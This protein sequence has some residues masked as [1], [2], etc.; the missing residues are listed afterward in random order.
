MRHNRERCI[1]PPPPPPRGAYW[2]QPLKSSH[3]AIGG[4]PHSHPMVRFHG[5]LVPTPEE[6]TT[7]SLASDTTRSPPPP[8]HPHPH[9]QP[10]SSV[11]GREFSRTLPYR[12]QQHHLS[13]RDT[14]ASSTSSS[15]LGLYVDRLLSNS[16]LNSSGGG[17]R[18]Q[19]QQQLHTMPEFIG[20][21]KSEAP[22]RASLGEQATKVQQL[23]ASASDGRCDSRQLL[24]QKHQQQYLVGHGEQTM[25]RQKTYDCAYDRLIPTS[26]PLTVSSSSASVSAGGIAGPDV[27]V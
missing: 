10:H 7:T 17:G 20:G 5:G 13:L 22:T 24:Q 1:P 15:E 26:I 25:R 9:L 8:S 14:T 19:L 16:H 27:I 6:R 21:L 12:K 4:G 23:G 3:G 2:L 18:G 11:G